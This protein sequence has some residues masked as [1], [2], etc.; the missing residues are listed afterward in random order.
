MQVLYFK[1][2]VAPEDRDLTGWG[3]ID[4]ETAAELQDVLDA[5]VN[6][7]KVPGM[8]AYV[9]TPDNKTWFGVSGTVD[10]KRTALLRRDHILGVGSITKLFTAAVILQLVEEGKLSLEEPLSNW[11]PELPNATNITISHLLNHTSGVPD[12]VKSV[13]TGG[14]SALNPRIVWNPTKLIEAATR[15]KPLF[16]PGTD[17][18]YS[19]TNYILL[20]VIAERLTGKPMPKLYQECIFKP[21]GLKH[22]FFPPYDTASNLITGFDRD[23]IPVP[24]LY[25]NKPEDT[26]WPSLVY[27]A[28]AIAST[29]EDVGIFLDSLFSKA[30]LSDSMLNKMID[31]CDLCDPDI[32]LTTGYGSGLFRY[33]I[34][35]DELWGHAGQYIGFEAMALYCPAENY[36]IVV[37][38]NVS[39]FD[40][41]SIVTR[42]Q[43]VIAQR[44]LD[45]T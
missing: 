34:G 28:G 15:R 25:K 6:D 27:S 20:G 3:N 4:T 36:I 2:F 5:A 45:I 24:G 39:L 8:Q 21:L 11:F 23:F 10:F 26:S 43:E 13:S 32:P 35:E 44:F 29:A 19:N 18:H 9:R 42:L 22:T 40:V 38:G 16:D 14:R 37:I 41:P 1:A 7:L 31:F 30:V 33:E 17:C 12:V